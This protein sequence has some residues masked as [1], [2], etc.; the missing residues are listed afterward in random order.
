MAADE[1]QW[2]DLIDLP[3]VP[4]RAKAQGWT[5]LALLRPEPKGRDEAVLLVQKGWSS[6]RARS[7]QAVS[8]RAADAH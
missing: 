6:G 3:A 5:E 7:A 1:V 4:A 2:L 8:A